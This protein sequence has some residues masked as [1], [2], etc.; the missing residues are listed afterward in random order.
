M[1]RSVEDIRRGCKVILGKMHAKVPIPYRD[2]MA[3]ETKGKK[4]KFGY[5]LS[6]G[7]IKASPACQRAVTESVDALRKA[8]HECVAFTPPDVLEAMKIFVGLTAADGYETLLSHLGP[9]PQE[10]SLF[11]VTL[12]PKLPAVLR[13]TAAWAAEKSFKDEIFAE[14]LRHSRPR[15]TKQLMEVTVARDRYI[16][17]WET[18]VWNK[19]GFDGI[20]CPVVASPGLP[21]GATKT[22]SPLA[23]GTILY[24]IVKSAVGVIPVVRVDPAKDKLSEEWKRGSTIWKNKNNANPSSTTNATATT[25]ADADATTEK[26]EAV[27]HP[28]GPHGSR[29][30]EQDLYEGGIGTK[31]SYDPDAMAG[32][33]V[34]IQIVGKLYED[35]KVIE[36]MQIVDEALGERGFGPGSSLQYSRSSV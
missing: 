30:I 6:D 31:R 11:L 33:P 14:C 2:E 7:I 17:M 9:D 13:K 26:T 3:A 19:M 5:Y 20:I 32:L 10:E 12:G 34:G 27:A 25:S 35:E 1:G 28:S 8:G 21:H 24:N 16:Q 29:I 18:E 23:C 4:L 22:L 15:S 36:M